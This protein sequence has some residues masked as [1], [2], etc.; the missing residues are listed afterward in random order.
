MGNKDSG[1]QVVK[2]HYRL[3]QCEDLKKNER[4][5]GRFIHTPHLIE[6]E[7]ELVRYIHEFS[8]S[9]LFNWVSGK[10]SVQPWTNAFI[11]FFLL[12]HFVSHLIKWHFYYVKS[13][14][15]SKILT[16]EYCLFHHYRSQC[17]GAHYYIAQESVLRSY[18]TV[19]I[20]F[21]C[22][23]LLPIWIVYC[24]FHLR[25][26]HTQTLILFHVHSIRKL[27]RV[28]FLKVWSSDQPHQCHLG[29]Y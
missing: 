29:I 18:V 15:F 9:K 21:L 7:I 25:C 3:R 24:N 22:I 4:R 11:N 26:A 27:L 5:P 2:C 13:V 28:A 14:M 17:E 12:Q 19:S 16:T 20:S 10:E 23:S 1:R 8:A 6:E